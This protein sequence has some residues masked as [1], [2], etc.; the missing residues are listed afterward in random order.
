[1]A[2]IFEA[3]MIPC[4]LLTQN[5]THRLSPQRGESAEAWAWVHPRE[6]I[7]IVIWAQARQSQPSGQDPCLK[8]HLQ[9]LLRDLFCRPCGVNIGHNWCLL[10]TYCAPECKSFYLFLQHCSEVTILW[11]GLGWLL[12]VGHTAKLDSPNSLA[13]KPGGRT[14]SLVK[15]LL[16][17]EGLVCCFPA[18]PAYHPHISD[19]SCSFL[20]YLVK[21]SMVMLGYKLEGVWLLNHILEVNHCSVTPGLDFKRAKIN[22]YCVKPVRFLGFTYSSLCSLHEYSSPF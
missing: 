20:L 9:P 2:G 6:L 22:F 18:W 7:V 1:M 5:W 14:E 10:N 4:L 13:V 16:V 8:Q 15:D 17:K 19:P 11:P 12:A 21:T 3:S